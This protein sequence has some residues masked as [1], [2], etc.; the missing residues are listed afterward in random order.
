MSEARVTEVAAI[1][2]FRADL[3]DFAGAVRRALT[4]IQLEVRRAMDWITVEQPGHWQAEVRRGYDAVARA[5]DELAH[6]R[7]YKQI[8]DYIP[9]CDDEKKAVEMAKHR[10]EHAEEKLQT[11]RRWTMAARRAVDE[12]Q[13]PVQQL[14][15]LLDGD[16]PHAMVLLERM[17]MALEQ[18][19]SGR[20]PAAI[21]WEE[22]AANKP[23]QSMA[24]PTDELAASPA[25]KNA[26]QSTPQNSSSP[27]PAGSVN[28]R[29]AE[30]SLP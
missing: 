6:A 21:T 7:T 25:E 3:V 5:K 10:L 9:S 12:F 29:A 11:V 13:G 24:R 26:D 22:L 15:G 2:E 18:Y 8:G 1:G 23:G 17:S 27:Q 20:T 14:M 30:S 4:D 16:I 19:T 28:P